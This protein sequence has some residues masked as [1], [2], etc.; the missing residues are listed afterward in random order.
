MHTNKNSWDKFLVS[1]STIYFFL[2]FFHGFSHHWGYLSSL[3]DIGHFDQAIWGA[4]N[5]FSLLNTD[6]FNQY[7]NRLGIHF[8]PILYL[9]VPLYKTYPTVNWLIAAQSAAISFSA[10]P[11]YLI[12]KD[13][14]LSEK[15]A[16]IW[17]IAYLLNPFLISAGTWDFHPITLSLPF[18]AYA[19]LAI[20]KDKIKLLLFCC[21]FLL[22]CKEHMGFAV[23]GLGILYGLETHKW[24]A[25]SFIAVFG[26]I[27]LLIILTK[28][29]PAY[30]TTGNHIMF[31]ESSGQL[32]R[33]QWLGSSIS[34]II[35]IS[36]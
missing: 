30:S 22:L 19:L 11:I 35:S 9:F 27:C 4:A 25:A 5:G 12:V 34:E 17:S 29:M 21:F 13:I 33:Y 36:A 26:I 8:D 23:A 10:W 15:T 1:F 7:A 14:S 28:I 32:S 2:L 6:I 18:M 20:L 3:N 24:K 31:S 16:C